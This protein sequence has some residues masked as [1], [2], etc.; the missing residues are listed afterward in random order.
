MACFTN[1]LAG[2]VAAT[3]T[4]AR[5]LLSIKT[6]CKA[7]LTVRGCSRKF[8]ALRKLSHMQEARQSKDNQQ[9]A[10]IEGGWA[11]KTMF[12]KQHNTPRYTVSQHTWEAKLLHRTDHINNR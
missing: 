6:F 12:A 3:L 7:F 1:W 2:H 11:K 5:L 9:D 4:L 10:I 8:A